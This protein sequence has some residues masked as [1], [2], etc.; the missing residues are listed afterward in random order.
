MLM[1]IGQRL[2]KLLC[3]ET[4]YG[5]SCVCYKIINL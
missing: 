2:T 1:Q 5:F 3:Y 4:W